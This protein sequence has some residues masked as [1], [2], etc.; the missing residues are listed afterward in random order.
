[1]SRPQIEQIARR[2][3]E[4]AE[5]FVDYRAVEE[6]SG[7]LGFATSVRTL[8]FYVA[9][10]VL[11]P[12]LRQGKT[13][14]YPR[15]WILNALLAIH[16][17]KTRLRRSLG[18]IRR[19]IQGIR[20]DPELLADKCTQLYELSSAPGHLAPAQ[21]FAVVD[22][23]FEQLDGGRRQPS[24]VLVTDLA[25]EVAREA[26]TAAPGF[27]FHYG[28]RTGGTRRDADRPSAAEVS[29]E[30]RSGAAGQRAARS[31]EMARELENVFIRGFESAYG[32][33]DAVFDPRDR[34]KYST[35]SSSRDPEIADDYLR[36]VEILKRE[37]RFDRE[38]FDTL[39]LG[40]S[41]R[42]RIDAGR[43]AGR[44]RR[45][46]IVGASWS[47]IE[48]LVRDGT[49]TARAGRADLCRLLDR[50]VRG[51][52]AFCYI[53]VHSTVG[54]ESE[55]TRFPPRGDDYRVA[56]VEQDEEAGWLLWHD[57]P[58]EAARVAALFDPEPRAEKVE[59]CRRRLEMLPDLRVRGGFVVL[60][61]IPARMGVSEDILSEALERLTREASGLRVQEVKG[62][63]ILKRDRLPG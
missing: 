43:R 62:R 26:E 56:L 2:L 40:K 54:W 32:N 23:F 11:P 45:I 47:P 16:L 9:E 52:S 19:V 22:R 6:E 60:G 8:R 24:E 58:P 46:E 21:A 50:I 15:D 51:G 57:F 59:R 20:E 27:S 48:D 28:E 33:L 36:V 1:M 53:G 44:Q 30:Q 3:Q 39:P 37:R 41:T 14:V 12:P 10:G 61:E 18:E 4:E 7:R 42:F 25:E 34:R 17:M 38:L 55:V 49:S 35:R 63:R 5:S 29:G 31:R 13:P